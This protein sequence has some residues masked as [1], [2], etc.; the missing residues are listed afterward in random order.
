MG[1]ERDLGESGYLFCFAVLTS[2]SIAAA[3]A[4][5]NCA[6]WAKKAVTVFRQSW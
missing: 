4:S 6:F 2:L 5:C 3:Y 1:A